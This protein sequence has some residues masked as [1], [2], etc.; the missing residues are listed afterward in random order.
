MLTATQP[1]TPALPTPV[2]RV[3][4]QN[5][6]QSSAEQAEDR[7]L[8]A[9]LIADDPQAWQ[10]FNAR[11]SRLIYRCITRVTTR[12]S[13]VVGQ[14]DVREIFGTLCLSLLARDK[15]K[16]RS[17]EFGRGNK[18]GSWIGML[19]VHATYDHLRSIKREPRR[20]SALAAEQLVSSFPDP[21]EQLLLRQRAEIASSLLSHF[22]EKDQQFITLYYGESLEP[23]RIAEQMG[24][25]IKTVYSKKHKIRSRLAMLLE[26]NAKAA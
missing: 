6:E 26:E 4:S 2:L 21:Y 15:H 17:F 12:F 1:S 5:T 19:A 16:L 13:S 24:I 18:F 14:D 3:H 25:S 11:Y 20:A 22:S 7:A 9:G 10:A 23:E 8:L